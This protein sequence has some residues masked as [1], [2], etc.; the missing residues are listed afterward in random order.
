MYCTIDDVSRVLPEK[1]K[2]GDINIGTPTPGRTGIKRDNVTTA[3]AQRYIGYAQEYIDARLRPFY[4]CP[5]RRIKVYE[6]EL[7]ANVGH[8]SNISITVNDSGEFTKGDLVRLQDKNQM[9]TCEV[10]NLTGLTTLTLVRVVNNYSTTENPVVS[11]LEFPDPIP[12]ITARLAS[13]F[14]LDRLFVSEQSPDVSQYGKT[15]RNLATAGIDSILTGEVLLFGQEHT[16]R[17]FIRGSL[18]NAY[19]SPA[20]MRK[21]EEKE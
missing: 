4:S 5:L 20:E 14:I 19:K 13:S 8:G 1:V 9:E 7:L 12:I 17:R 3:D 15:Q 16:G 21:G 6:T 11:I 2:I 18:F 10:N